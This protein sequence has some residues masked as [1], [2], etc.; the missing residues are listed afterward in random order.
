MKYIALCSML[1]IT[2]C[3]FSANTGRNVALRVDDTVVVTN[4]TPAILDQNTLAL[5][6]T[7][8]TFSAGIV[9]KNLIGVATLKPCK[10]TDAK[11][12]IWG[13]DLG[14]IEAG[15]SVTVKF[16]GTL[17]SGNLFSYEKGSN[18]FLPTVV[19]TK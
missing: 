10:V 12:N 9:G 15:K 18:K 7:D 4:Y 6:G 2:S 1:L 16:K 17:L 3:S 19:V 13:C 14:V 8:S 5:T 11:A